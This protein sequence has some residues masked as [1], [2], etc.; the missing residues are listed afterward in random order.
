[1]VQRYQKDRTFQHN[2]RIISKNVKK[3]EN[4]VFKGNTLS[5]IIYCTADT[6]KGLAAVIPL[7]I[8]SIAKAKPAGFFSSFKVLRN[9]KAPW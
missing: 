8:S 1:M 2:N 4:P 9:C 6:Y 5:Y 3:C 7:K